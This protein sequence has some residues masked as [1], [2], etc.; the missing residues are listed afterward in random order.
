MDSLNVSYWS[1]DHK[2]ITLEALKEI[3]DLLKA[4]FEAHAGDLRV[5]MFKGCL[6]EFQ[7]ALDAHAGTVTQAVSVLGV[8][9]QGANGF[10][11]WMGLEVHESH[12]VCLIGTP[13]ALESLSLRY[14]FGLMEFTERLVGK[15]QAPSDALI[16]KGPG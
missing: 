4:R 16:V 7:T 6:A 9:A 15:A 2:P 3:G 1:G 12:G 8:F 11:L 13:A 5:F 10:P 14:F